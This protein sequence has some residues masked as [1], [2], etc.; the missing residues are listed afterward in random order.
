MQVTEQKSKPKTKPKPQATKPDESLRSTIDLKTEAEL[1][2]KA[3][4]EISDQQKASSDIP[5]IIAEESAKLEKVE[6]VP[7][8]ILKI[9][10]V[11]KEESGDV[12][13]TII[14]EINEENVAESVKEGKSENLKK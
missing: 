9:A 2:E 1:T 10:E 6:T 4:A 13:K 14:A 8:R 3:E 7:E 5:K 12:D 11:I